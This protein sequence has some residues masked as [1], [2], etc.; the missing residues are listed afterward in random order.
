MSSGRELPIETFGVPKN[1]EWG[2]LLWQ[3]LHGA[4][5]KL[6]RAPNQSIFFDQRR[7][8]I[9]V[10]R[11]VETIMPCAL[12]R[13]HYKE[14]RTRRPIDQFPETQAEFREAVRKW[15][16]DLH[17]NINTSHAYESGVTLDQLGPMYSTYD[18]KDLARQ[19]TFLMNRAVSLKAIDRE[20]LRRFNTHYAFLSR[21]L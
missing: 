8:M 5:E 3:M 6:G 18:L 10:L 20:L 2:P 7:E 12:C 11:Y 4:A 16:F 13:N 9:F 19:F 15:L 14:W 1:S 17:E 21:I